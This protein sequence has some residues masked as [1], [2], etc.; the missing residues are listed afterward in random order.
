MQENFWIISNSKKI[1]KIH[2]RGIGKINR[3]GYSR[4]LA[5]STGLLDIACSEEQDSLRTSYNLDRLFFLICQLIIWYHLQLAL[6]KVDFP[7]QIIV[8]FMIELV[9]CNNLIVKLVTE[10]V[11]SNNSFRFKDCTW[12]SN[13]CLQYLGVLAVYTE[14]PVL[15]S[16]YYPQSPSP[17][18]YVNK[19]SEAEQK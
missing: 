10:L 8:E 6:S 4:C 18:N 14:L 1:K 2:F 5:C 11:E 17:L 19:K 12:L 9:E 7:A 16:C 3:C 15:K 13:L